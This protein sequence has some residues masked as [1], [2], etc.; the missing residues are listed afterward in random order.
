MARINN[1]LSNFAAGELSPRLRGRKDLK[2]YYNGME[3]ISNFIVETQ[4]PA[5]FRNGTAYV[6]HTRLNQV[7][8]LIPFQFSDQQAYQLEFTDKYI[9]I[10]RNNGAVLE[11]AKTISGITLAN[12]GVVT[13]NGHGFSDGDE[14]FV[15][16]VV[17]MVEVNAQYYIVAN[18][19]TN[20]FELTDVDGANINTSG[21]AAYVSG[22]E[23]SRIHEVASP[24]REA[25]LKELKV[26]QN[27]DTMYIAH[28]NYEPR[29]LTRSGHASW[30]LDTF[31]RTSDPFL[32]K[33]NITNIT[34]ANP[35]VVTISGHPY[36]T[37]DVI[38]LDGVV[39]M[40]EIN[41]GL[42][43][44]EYIGAN[45]FSLKDVNGDDVDTTGFSAYASGGYTSYQNLLP[46]SV[47]FYEARLL[48]GRSD[49]FPEKFW[50]SR[51]PDS[52]GVP[53]FDDFT[54]GSDADHAV[55]FTLAPVNGKV[56]SI[57]WLSGNTKYLALGTFGGVTKVTGG[58]DDEAITPTG[59]T[60]KP[61]DG[62]GCRNSM[63]IPFGNII[64]YVQLGGLVVRSLEYSVVDDG[65]QAVDRVLVSDHITGAGITQ[66]AFSNG[67]PDILWAVRTDGVLLGLTF[68]PKEDVSGWHRHILGGTD[69]KVLSV[70]VIPQPDNRDQT[71]VV[72]ER[73]VDGLT[74]RYVEYFTNEIEYP[75][76]LEYFSGEDN[77]STDDTKFLN[78][79]FEQ[80]KKYI[81]IDSALTYDGSAV[82]SDAGATVTP[83]ATTG[84]AITFTTDADIFTSD[85][86]GN[87]IW[88]KLVNS[89]GEG[90]VWSGRA[91]IVAF[92]SAQEVTCNIIKDFDSVD[93]LAPGQWF[94]TAGSI[95]GLDH[96]EGETVR[97]IAD[98]S[99]HP[100]ETVVDGSIT[101]DYEVSA[102]HVGCGYKGVLRSMMLEPGSASGSGATK[103]KNIDEVFFRFLNTL[104]VKYGLDIYALEQLVFRST[105]D[106]GSRPS[107][108]FSGIKSVKYPD[109]WQ[110]E[111]HI[112]LVQELPLPCTVQFMDI[113]GEVVDDQ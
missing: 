88:K 86:V 18:K 23:V 74:R 77:D 16:G 108:L 66:L 32:D 7:A 47:S 40:T 83:G 43:T 2:L 27:A 101:L 78:A 99:V 89:D 68:K 110:R 58:R 65:Y 50:G 90:Q 92:V 52:A 45:S 34:Q 69:A 29:K 19:T 44:L 64:I 51:G 85:S 30:S 3:H 35:G 20:S 63:P 36:S 53:R 109:K 104:G 105:G 98:G 95:S 39:G 76:R 49:S 60:A 22:G 4:G 82:T 5:R 46:G 8:H 97:V 37:G 33:E 87:Q 81:H 6:N 107:P 94:L 62:H 28:P 42:Y 26:A 91:E 9:R 54:T 80:Q 1:V 31:T 113:Y 17:G 102:A 112:N 24:Y 73:T 12:P 38:L 14:V 93:A 106:I 56:D 15:S 84:D 13:A 72:V 111:K 100:D 41:G 61:I 70:G 79:M 103:V 96:L 75:D 25:D 11:S 59:I 21:F 57:Q 48:Y 71:W 67:R 10:F 55:I